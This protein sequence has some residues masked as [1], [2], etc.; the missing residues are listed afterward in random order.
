MNSR[1][2]CSQPYIS[3]IR[4]G[5]KLV[6]GDFALLLFNGEVT[7]SG[8]VVVASMQVLLGAGDDF[9]SDFVSP[10]EVTIAVAV[11]DP[12][13][14]LDAALAA[15]LRRCARICLRNE[16]YWPRSSSNNR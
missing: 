9:S 15:E 5:R 6:G 4:S 7:V 10:S 8:A 2:R 3:D 14:V 11:S 16:L 13:S 12:P 1:R